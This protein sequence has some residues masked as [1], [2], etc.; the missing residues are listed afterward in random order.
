MHI[1]RIALV[2]ALMVAPAAAA[3]VPVVVQATPI[4]APDRTIAITGTGTVKAMPDTAIISGGV[5][6]RAKRAGDALRA[7]NE[8]MAKA[9]AALK[10]L[11]LEDKQIATSSFSFEPQYETDSKGNIDPDR[12]I[13]GYIVSNRV[14]VTLKDKIERAGEVLDAM[15]QNG[16]NDSAN[17]QI[18]IRDV[19]AVEMQARAAA[20]KDALARAQTYVR[21]LGSELGAVR[22]VREGV[23]VELVDK[24]V[25]EDIGRFPDQGVAN[26][27]QRIP[28]VRVQA[29][30]QTITKQV[31]VVW[32]LR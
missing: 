1:S 31:T 6:A 3:T 12:R 16:A 17:V 2:A 24:I 18:E 8:A 20:A 4:M 9:V 13:V 14:S 11:G 23:Q 10:A 29:D 7:N 30:E 26:A 22:S 19:E 27:L 15:L 5:I 28:G 32:A 21:Q 25:A